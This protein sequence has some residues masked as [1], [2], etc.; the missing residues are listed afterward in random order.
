[1]RAPETAPV[2]PFFK[3]YY[4]ATS[5]CNLACDY[6][7]LE[8]APYQL[9]QE[10]DLAGKLSLIDHLYHRFGFRRLTLSGGE[11]LI[12]GK[13]PPSDF[14]AL[15][16]HLRQY[17]SVDP[18]ENLEV[19][20]Y[21]NGAFLDD[22]VADELA[23]VVDLVAITIDSNDESLLRRIGRNTGRWKGYYQRAV[24]VCGRLSARGVRV[25]LHSV[26]GTLNHQRLGGEVR[27]IYDAIIEAGGQIEKW[28][29]YQYMS[30]DVP[31][32]DGL[33]G[34]TAEQYARTTEQIA[35]AMAGTS[36]SLH[37]KDN[38]EMN[39]SL[40][41]ILP[42]GN[43]QYMV[44]GDT[45]STSRRTG[46]LRDYSSIPELLERHDINEQLFRRYHEITR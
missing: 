33:H 10:L 45:W 3:G 14:I 42:Y 31:E 29:F 4:M 30:Y 22:R 46:D 24:D 19:V 40:F 17:R 18:R 21:T 7:V 13:K 36:V 35:Q 15:L 44:P 8:D 32:K 39:E 25:K 5:R 6:C 26:V 23:D 28:K 12:I 43:A 2:G 41:N 27:P 20:L 38:G 11:M 1:M 16:C 34:L 37:F 9:R